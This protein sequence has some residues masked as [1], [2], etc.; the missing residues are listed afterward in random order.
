MWNTHWQRSH[1]KE[2]QPH[3]TIQINH[4]LVYLYWSVSTWICDCYVFVLADCCFPE[5]S[6]L[7]FLISASCALHSH[8]V[9]LRLASCWLSRASHH[10]PHRLQRL[11]M[12]WPEH[13][14]APEPNRQNDSL[15]SACTAH[16]PQT[17]DKQSVLWWFDEHPTFRYGCLRPYLQCI[18]DHAFC[19]KSNALRL[20]SHAR[21]SG[22][23][24]YY[25]HKGSVFTSGEKRDSLPERGP[26]SC[27]KSQVEKLI[28]LFLTSP[29][30][31]D[32]TPP[33]SSVCHCL[34][35]R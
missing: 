22:Q 18:N 1:I 4:S 34:R 24:F 3:N 19:Q 9:L 28:A 2:F 33:A 27:L 10:K 31:G 21:M 15:A 7:S 35:D 26:E 23:V 25:C 12:A 29:V 14:W 5:V 13:R 16:L 20:R 6:V 32:K 30:V 11:D 17:L 8:R